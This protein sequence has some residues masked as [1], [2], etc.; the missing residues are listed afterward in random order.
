VW[1]SGPGDVYAAGY[2]GAMRHFDGTTWKAVPTGT[3]QS[4][5]AVWGHGTSVLYIAGQGGAILR[6]W[7]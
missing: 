2:A 3:A 7:P 1:G 4:L 6:R 5:R